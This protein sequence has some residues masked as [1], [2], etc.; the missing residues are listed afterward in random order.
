M[1]MGG[2]GDEKR[3]GE[4]IRSALGEDVGKGDITSESLISKTA[5]VSARFVAGEEGVLAGLA[6]AEMV[7]KEIDEA[8]SF[9]TAS[10]EGARIKP[11]KELAR[12]SG[13]ARS[14]LSGERCALNF[15]QRLSGIATLTAKFVGAVKDTGAKIYDTRKTTPNLRILEKYAVSIGGGCNHRMGLYDQVLIKDNHIVAARKEGLKKLSDMVQKVRRD[16]SAD[17]KIEIE[18]D[19]LKDLEDALAGSPDMI[20]LDNM[21]PDEMKRA[22]RLIKDRSRRPLIEASGNINLKN[23]REVAVSGVDIISVGALTHSARGLDISLEFE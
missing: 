11:G 16:V 21:T 23:V 15:L 10:A 22:V 9:Q 18:V 5:K 14:I 17:V 12:I 4:I 20:M 13:S 1:G 6:V 7:F 19:N 2:F 3:V 8:I